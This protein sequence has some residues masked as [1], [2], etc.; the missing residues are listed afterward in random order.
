MGLDSKEKMWRVIQ[1]VWV[2]MLCFSASRSRGYL[3]A[4]SLG[5]GG[6][7]LSYIWLLW[8]HAGMETFSERLQRRRHRQ[9]RGDDDSGP[10]SS[11]C[12]NPVEAENASASS[13]ASKGKEPVKEEDDVVPSTSQSIGPVKEEGN[14]ASAASSSKGKATVMEEDAAATTQSASQCDTACE[15]EIVVDSPPNHEV[16]TPH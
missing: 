16:H 9:S 4:K 10:S 6:E 11:Q 13:S 3:H 1:G 2:E 15:I 7:F 5:S 12:T 8:A 14:A